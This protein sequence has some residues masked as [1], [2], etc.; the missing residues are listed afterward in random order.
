M[1]NVEL[2]VMVR[3]WGLAGVR[4]PLVRVKIPL[5]VVLFP[6]VFVRVIIPDGVELLMVRFAA[7][8]RPVPVTCPVAPLKV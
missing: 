7:A 1:A 6:D 2:L 5:T 8:V 3:V 4:I